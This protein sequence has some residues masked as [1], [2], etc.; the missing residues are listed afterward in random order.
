V[1]QRPYVLVTGATGFV[2]AAIV[3]ALQAVADVCAIS[4]Q[5]RGSSLALD[6][7]DDGAAAQLRRALDRRSPDL[8]VHSAA[9]L[10]GQ[11]TLETF[12]RTNA[13]GTAR[14][15]D[16]LPQPP[17]AVAFLSTVDIYGDA[18]ANPITIDTAA[19][20]SSEYAISKYAGERTALRWCRERGV[21]FAIFRLAQV[22][23]PGDPTSKVIPRFCA[24]AVRGERPAL[25]GDGAE[26]RQPVHVDDVSQAMA[27]WIKRD[28]H[29][30]AE[31]FLIAGAEV[32]AIRTLAEIVMREAGLSG[33]PAQTASTR[34]VMDQTFD[35]RAT[36]AAL[37]WQPQMTLE[38]GIRGVL[39]QLRRDATLG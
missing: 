14:L 37:G 18:A 28:A 15:L 21:S 3:R 32:V 23:G 27:Q 16:G 7:D 39:A 12:L 25:L 9:R 2:G 22:Y 34:P 20:P 6:L 35:L 29:T 24:A 31:T 8:V 10:P 26:R 19:A 33:T 38:R 1:S 30:A 36:S 5:G 4:R 11:G 13:V 17:R